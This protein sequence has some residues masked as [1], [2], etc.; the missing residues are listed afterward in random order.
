MAIKSHCRYIH[1]IAEGRK[2]QRHPPL[3]YG[4]SPKPD[5]FLLET[6][7]A[8]QSCVWPRTVKPSFTFSCSI[9]SDAGRFNVATIF[10]YTA[11][12]KEQFDDKKEKPWLK[13]LTQYDPPRTFDPTL[14]FSTPRV[15]QRNPFGRIEHRHFSQ[16]KF[17]RCSVTKRHRQRASLAG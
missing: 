11:D 5:L 4:A 6:L 3:Q 9:S 16:F 17:D 12:E 8:Q 15:Q 7:W 1:Y 2:I 14:R 13:I 10:V